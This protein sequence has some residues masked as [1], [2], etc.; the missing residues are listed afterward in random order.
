MNN[1]SRRA[2]WLVVG[3]A[4]LA[5]GA[6]SDDA[7]GSDGAVA[8]AGP[9]T[10]TSSDATAD[11]TIQADAALPP[12]TSWVATAACGSNTTI[13]PTAVATDS[14]GNTYVAG[15]FFG[16]VSFGSTDLTSDGNDIFVAKLDATG[17][18]TKAVV[19]TSGSTGASN[20][21]TGLAV[22]G[23]DNLFLV[24]TIRDTA[25]FGATT[26][27]PGKGRVVVARLDDKLS[28]SWAVQA[29]A[30]TTVPASAYDEGTAI[31]VGKG[32]QVVVVGSVHHA[33]AKFGALSLA[34]AGGFVAWLDS[35]GTFTRVVSLGELSSSTDEAAP[36]AVAVDAAGNVF[37]AGRFSG[38]VKFGAKSFSSSHYDG[39]VSRLDAKGAVAWTEVVKGPAA[40]RI[41]DLALGS[42]GE[43]YVTGYFG[44]RFLAMGAKGD[45]TFGG[46]TLTSTGNLADLLVARLDDKG[47]V[48]WASGANTKNYSLATAVA[49]APGGAVLAGRYNGGV[50]LGQDVLSELGSDDVFLAR[51]GEAG[52]FQWAM[53]AGSKG[54]SYGESAT[55]LA[56]DAAG[57][58]TVV[59]VFEGS[60]TFGDKTVT[61]KG[62][63]RDLYVWRLTAAGK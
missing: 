17:T 14:K 10:T 56:L 50:V 33:G 21:A 16:T 53:S 20:E 8:D 43:L 3:A 34:K 26:L 31:A 40:E 47:A 30:A 2:P 52:A 27:S 48:K 39:F 19:P 32:G 42:A 18:F 61:A 63:D 12:K 5:L 9:D 46:K 57:G 58:V 49:A 36:G 41:M 25:T 44:N 4:L 28:F 1:D 62:T 38:T 59:G 35:A 55:D 7:A 15:G 6:C 24:A 11:Q 45:A 60:A 37:A 51:V 23:A 29:G 13:Y 54:G 22:D